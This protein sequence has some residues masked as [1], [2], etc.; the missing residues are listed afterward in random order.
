MAAH[1]NVSPQ[2]VLSFWR[3]AGPERWFASDAAFDALCAE[4]W[5]I[6]WE[7]AQA[8]L[9]DD[10]R[11]TAEGA[12]ALVLLL[13]QMPRN[14]F[15]GTPRAYASDARARAVA[16]D[17]IERGLHLQVEPAMRRFFHLPFSHAEDAAA[18]DRAVALAEAT[19]DEDVARW[20]RHHRDIIARFGRFPHRNAILGRAN[21]P[22]EAEWLAGEGA[23]KG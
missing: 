8:G 9:L 21:T 7:L 19:G 14:M 2:D 13:D 23:F 4:R 16:Q 22:D 5:E 17:A 15:R 18:Q 11:D 12:L 3:E 1:T 10:W 20:A 6:A